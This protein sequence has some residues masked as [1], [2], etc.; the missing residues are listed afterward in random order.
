MESSMSFSSKTTGISKYDEYLAD[1]SYAKSKGITVKVVHMSPETYIDI[2][3]DDFKNQGFTKEEVIASR[4]KNT[5]TIK[6]LEKVKNIDMPVLG[7][8]GEYLFQEGLH[9]SISA[10]NQGIKSM[11]VLID[12]RTKHKPSILKQNKVI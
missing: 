9:R 7:Y 10:I 5:E 4:K 8:D 2:A 12:Y 6:R 11:P 3:S 1:P